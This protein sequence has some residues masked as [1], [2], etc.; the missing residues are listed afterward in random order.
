M[1]RENDRIDP[2]FASSGHHCEGWRSPLDIV[3]KIQRQA[4]SAHEAKSA[5]AIC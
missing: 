4:L 1:G 3:I 5:E 2:L